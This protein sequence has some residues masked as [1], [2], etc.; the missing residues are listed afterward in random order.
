M[1]PIVYTDFLLDSQA[2][3][4]QGVAF[5]TFFQKFTVKNLNFKFEQPQN[6]FTGGND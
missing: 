5:K 1:S 3:H 6:N 4:K 2:G